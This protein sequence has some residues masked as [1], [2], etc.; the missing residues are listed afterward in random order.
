MPVFLFGVN[1]YDAPLNE[2]FLSPQ[3]H[4]P[5][6]ISGCAVDFSLTAGTAFLYSLADSG[7]LFMFLMIL[8]EPDAGFIDFKWINEALIG[9]KEMRKSSN[10]IKRKGG[11]DEKIRGIH[12]RREQG[13]FEQ[14]AQLCG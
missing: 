12:Q 14:C 8:D 1:D 7:R 3:I 9:F 10:F 2:E 6:R 13:A 11:R 5:Y 4:K